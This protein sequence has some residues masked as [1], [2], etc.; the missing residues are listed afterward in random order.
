MGIDGRGS[1]KESWSTIINSNVSGSDNDHD[2]D[3]DNDNDNKSD[4]EDWIPSIC[5]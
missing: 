1:N 3:N 5:C 2:D 4:G